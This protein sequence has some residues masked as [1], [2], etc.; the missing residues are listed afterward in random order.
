MEAMEEESGVTCVVCQEGRTLQPSELLGMYAYMKK[1]T[2]PLS[3]GGDRTDIDGTVMLLSL[4]ISCPRTLIGSQ[5]ET[6]FTKGKTAAKALRGTSHALGAMAI[7][8]SISGNS[9]SNRASFITSVSAGNAIHSSCHAKA[10][11]ADRS[12]PKAPK[13]EW[14]GASLRNS[15]VTCNV[16]LPLVS[17][18]ISNVPLIAVESALDEVNSQHTT[19]LGSRPKPMLWNILHDVRLLMLRMAYGEALN[20]DCGGGSASSNFLLA[21]YQLYTADMLLTKT[22]LD[23]SQAAKHARGLSP[24]FIAA[25]AIV[26]SVGFTR[27][28]TRSKRLER[29]VANAAPMAALCSILFLDLTNEG[30]V[31]TSISC[32]VTERKTPSSNRQWE[33]HKDTFLAGLL[34]CAG[35]RN[36]LGITDSGCVTSRGIST[37]SRKNIEKAR[38]FT[39]WNTDGSSMKKKSSSSTILEGYA[40]SLRPMITLYAILNSLSKEFV[41]NDTDENTLTASERLASTLESC[42]KTCSVVEL[43]EVAEITMDHDAICK[44]YEKGL[45][46]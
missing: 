30:V 8:A 16:I 6:F 13:S 44:F 35:L 28:D 43:L 23:D 10:K 34:R 32:D 39:D 5:N 37:E 33:T 11:A 38:S 19:I 25:S 26:N 29:G 7:A 14:E 15:R 12:H 45:L 42:L 9:T 40:I 18:K 2:I 24:G 3:Q 27:N 41:V 21:L 46:I 22:G 17:S 20:I 1:V 4:P 31:D 36:A